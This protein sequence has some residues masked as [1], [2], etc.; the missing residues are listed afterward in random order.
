MIDS[1]ANTANT[2]KQDSSK[3]MI[4]RETKAKRREERSSQKSFLI[5]KSQ[6]TTKISK[7]KMSAKTVKWIKMIGIPRLGVPNKDC[8]E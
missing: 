1:I 4:K 3:K 6:N 5:I 8:I 2:K 7:P